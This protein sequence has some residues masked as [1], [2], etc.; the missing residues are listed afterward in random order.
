MCEFDTVVQ[1]SDEE[2]INVS[3][4]I[5]MTKKITRMIIMLR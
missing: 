3:E 1:E 2:L 5:H 4:G